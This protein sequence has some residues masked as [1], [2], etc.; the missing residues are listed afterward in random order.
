MKCLPL[1]KKVF[2]MVCCLFLF[3]T[4]LFCKNM[5][6]QALETAVSE[7]N[8]G[9]LQNGDFLKQRKPSESSGARPAG[10]T[11]GAKQAFQ[12]ALENIAP[13]VSLSAYNITV[14]ELNHIVSEVV[15]NNPKYFY[16][17]N[18]SY[19]YYP[20]N[21]QVVDVTFLY[22][23]SADA[24]RKK[25]GIYENAV[26][27]ILNTVD[28]SWSDLEK[29]LYVNDYLAT[30][31]EYDTTY[32]KYSSYNVFVDKTAVCQGYALAYQ[33]LMNRLNIPC[34]VVS[35]EPLDHAWNLVKIGS[36]WYHVDVTWNDPLSDQ[37]GQARHYYYMKSTSWF[38]GTAGG[39]ISKDGQTQYVYSKDA[40]D[41]T[42]SNKAYDSYFW[43][44]INHSFGYYKG[45]W[46]ANKGGTLYRYRLNHSGMTESSEYKKLNQNWPVW[47]GSGWWQGAYGGCVVYGKN[48]YYAS[49]SSIQVLNL[50][51]SSA[52]AKTAFTPSADKLSQGYIYGFYIDIDGNLYYGIAKSPNEEAIVYSEK[53]HT[54]TYG[55]W[56]VTKQANCK[57]SGQRKQFCSGCGKEK[58]EVIQPDGKHT[59]GKA[60]TCT[61]PQT[62]TVC[63][64]VIKKATGHLHKK[65]VTKAATFT[66]EGKKT[67]TCKD[68]GQVL[69][70]KKIAKI[71]CKKGQIYKVG[72]YKYKIVS[73]KTNGKGTVSFAGLTKNVKKV[74]VGDTV[75]IHG[76][77]F[78]IVKIEDR[79][80]KNKTKV[81]SVTIGKNVTS[82]G[83]ESFR[84]A[85]NLKNITI[86][87]TKITKVG[88]K[89][90][91]NI[92]S[93]AK[94]KVPK[95]KL[96]KYKA[97]MK[98]KGQKKTVK[99]C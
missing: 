47:N 70:N 52:P 55:A 84:G 5:T 59:L 67:V 22:T 45:Y 7:E 97:L 65:T 89:A 74:T 43:N 61:T 57:E 99:I 33:E 13:T 63:K 95:S 29:A 83:K 9:I 4:L 90:F 64:T 91:Q 31:C 88:T 79:A 96:K 54:H 51:D 41:A 85:K 12:N 87:S 16:Y 26:K 15:N 36:S 76:S 1:H 35:S 20:S 24:V 80:L 10:N 18:C 38:Q 93:K 32:S 21:N 14:A 19:R 42:A 66:K 72:N 30:N 77:K 86:K 8:T 50:A 56:T 39:H 27:N 82:I 28:S 81:T 34:Q 71:K 46:Y 48:L 17:V 60:A 2:R 58:V 37:L 49:P 94:I 3:S 92:H 75:K 23:E 44:E 40:T 11:S 78:K 98:N 6:A 25:V 68:C 73:N 53:F 62:C 69:E